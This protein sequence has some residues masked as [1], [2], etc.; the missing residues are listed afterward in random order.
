MTNL[1]VC[2]LIAVAG[3]TPVFPV[4][5]FHDAKNVYDMAFR[6]MPSEPTDVLAV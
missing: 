1:A 5:S 4:A 6:A 2:G 3:C